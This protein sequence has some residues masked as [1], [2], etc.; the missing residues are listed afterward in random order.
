[1]S[2]ERKSMYELTMQ[3]KLLDEVLGISASLKE[4][5]CL[6]IIFDITS[7]YG[8]STATDIANISGVPYS[9]VVRYL[10]S[11]EKAGLITYGTVSSS[12]RNKYVHLTAQGEYLHARLSDPSAHPQFGPLVQMQ[13]E[14]QLASVDRAARTEAIMAAAD[15]MAKTGMAQPVHHT[16]KVDDIVA[17]KAEVGEVSVYVKDADG[18]PASVKDALAMAKSPKQVKE[19]VEQFAAAQDEHVLKQVLRAVRE[20]AS[21]AK[22]ANYDTSVHGRLTTKWRDIEIQMPDPYECMEAFENGE[23]ERIMHNG[24]WMMYPKGAN[25]ATTLPLAVQR[26]LHDQPFEKLVAEKIDE[27]TAHEIAG[28][29][30][31]T[32]DAVTKELKMLLNERQYNKAR[33]EITAAVADFSHQMKVAKAQHEELAKEQAQIARELAKQAEEL[34]AHANIASLS[35]TERMDA[36]RWAN[37]KASQASRAQEDAMRNEKAKNQLEQRLAEV[38]AAAAERDRER[39]LKMQRMEEMLEQLMNEREA[40]NE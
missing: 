38:E 28:I 7:K 25:P 39:D 9:S 30:H 23:G 34:Q 37:E 17:I 22:S 15:D 19:A 32:L 11:F 1:M 6:P 8:G 14:A 31:V 27:L 5:M 35:T 26:D 10:K 3:I 21:R 2:T 13:V 24:I 16:L 29:A 33:T 18:N 36:R 40:N 20:Q 12:D 4:G